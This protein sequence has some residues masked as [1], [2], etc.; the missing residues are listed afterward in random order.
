MPIFG[1]I[2]WYL[3]GINL[4]CLSNNYGWEGFI[5]GVNI[6]NIDDSFLLFYYYNGGSLI[7]NKYNNF[8]A[9]IFL[10]VFQ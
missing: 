3:I 2:N 7:I 8:E 5:K 9:L 4:F 10:N 6:S 1:R